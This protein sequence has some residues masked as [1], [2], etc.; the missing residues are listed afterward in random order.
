ALRALVAVAVEALAPYAVADGEVEP[1]AQ[2][3][4]QRP[5]DVEVLLVAAV[6]LVGI[7]AGRL[8][9]ATGVKAILLHAPDEAAEQPAQEPFREGGLSHGDERREKR[10]ACDEKLDAAHGTWT[11]PAN[12]GGLSIAAGGKETLN[13]RPGWA[14][15]SSRRPCRRPRDGRA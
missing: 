3:H 14:I 12:P 13:E 7:E 15:K 11:G 4:A 8:A 5:V 9:H 2:A 10:R 1:I 6:R